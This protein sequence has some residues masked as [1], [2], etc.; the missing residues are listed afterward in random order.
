MIHVLANILSSDLKTS[1]SNSSISILLELQFSLEI[2]VVVELIINFNYFNM[3]TANEIT[4][5]HLQFA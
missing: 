1:I 5:T 2:S 4:V 3:H